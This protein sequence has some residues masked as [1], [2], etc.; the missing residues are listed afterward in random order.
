MTGILRNP[1]QNAKLP[2]VY[3]EKV[4]FFCSDPFTPA[5]SGA[6]TRLH[7]PLGLMEPEHKGDDQEFKAEA[8]GGGG[9]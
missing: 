9:R 3:L 6:N 7:Q 4:S 8:E 2:F 1:L 5:G